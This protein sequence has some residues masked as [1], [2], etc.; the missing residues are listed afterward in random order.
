MKTEFHRWFSPSLGKDMSVN[1]Y[2]HQG[3]PVIVFPSSGGSFHEFADFGMV[4]AVRPFIDE[5][6]I[7]LF[8]PDSVDN[9]SWLNKHISPADRAHR[10]NAYDAYII[11]ELVPL[12]ASIAGRGDMLATGCSLGAYHAM[13]FFLRHPDVFNA[14]VAL[15]GCYQLSYFVGDYCDENVYLNSPLYYLQNCNDPWYLD[16]YRH[17]AI[18]ACTGQGAWEEEMIHDTRWLGHIFAEK[19]IPAWC[20]FWGYDVNHDWPWWRIQLPYFLGRIL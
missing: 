19:G 1:V 3:K 5:G 14:V 4:E 17:S 9:E 2:G 20:D 12:A 10:H 11:Q 15:S 6:R 7:I 13:N 18:V 16:R 8:T